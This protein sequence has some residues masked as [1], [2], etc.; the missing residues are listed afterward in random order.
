[1][2]FGSVIGAGLGG[3][4]I[5]IVPVGSLKLLLGC[6][7]LVAA[8]KTCWSIGRREAA[9]DPNARM[10]SVA[11]RRLR[12]DSSRPHHPLGTRIPR[13]N[14]LPDCLPERP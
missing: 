12:A 5:A 1:M 10:L 9:P 4:A 3:L 6:V 8:A 2:S 7:L 14:N 11:D 13:A